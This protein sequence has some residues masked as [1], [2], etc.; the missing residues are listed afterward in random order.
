MSINP[1]YLA[2]FIIAAEYRNFTSAAERLF[3]NQSTLSRQIQSLEE[4]LH[5]PLFVRNG[6]NLSLTKAGQVLYETGQVVLKQMQEVER[7]VQNAASYENNRV[8]IYSVPAYFNATTEALRRMHVKGI[9]A[10]VI[11]HHLQTEDPQALLSSNAVDFLIMFDRFTV[12]LNPDEYIRIPFESGGFCVACSPSHPFAAMDSVTLHDCLKQ[13]VLF[14]LGFP[15]L[16]PRPPMLA[17]T[18][19]ISTPN[20]TIESFHDSVMLGEGVLLLPEVVARSYASDLRY[21]PLAEREL[22]Y[23]VELVYKKNRPLAPAARAYAETIREISCEYIA[24][25]A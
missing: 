24:G 22:N 21:I 17:E 23:R 5:T 7:L 16:S 4:S 20:G 15:G 11:I 9:S 10:D 14:G 25:D 18:G 12:K 2:N 3:I 13:N 1:D 6:K 8:I 19:D